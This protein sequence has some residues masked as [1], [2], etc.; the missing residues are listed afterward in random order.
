MCTLCMLIYTELLGEEQ[1]KNALYILDPIYIL[2]IFIFPPVC[3]VHVVK[4][5]DRYA[6]VLHDLRRLWN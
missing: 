4:E 3:N 2:Y 1:L 6:D 5:L